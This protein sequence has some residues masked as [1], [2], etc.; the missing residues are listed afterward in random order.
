MGKNKYF[1]GAIKFV[2]VYTEY[3][4]QQDVA[5]RF[6]KDI[7]PTPDPVT[8][9]E[10]PADGGAGGGGDGGAPPPDDELAKIKLTKDKRDCLGPC[11]DEPP[12][13]T[14]GAPQPPPE[15]ELG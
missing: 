1:Y 14:P 6:L 12:P 7:A 5:K 9:P 8:E 13:G 2:E 4:L 11:K 3:F 15:A 10:P